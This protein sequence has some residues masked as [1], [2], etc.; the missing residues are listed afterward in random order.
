MTTRWLAAG[1]VALLLGACDPNNDNDNDNEAGQIVDDLPTVPP[2]PESHEEIVLPEQVIPPATEQQYCL[3]LPPSD[4]DRFMVTFDAYQGKHGHHLLMF[5][6]IQQREPGTVIECSDPAIMAQLLPAAF[7]RNFLPRDP[8]PNMAVRIKAGA[9]LVIQQHYVNTSSNP[10]RTVDVLHLETLQ[11]S[12]VETELG[13]FGLTDVNFSLPPGKQ[14]LQFDCEVTRP[15]IRLLMFGPHMH[16]WGSRFVVEAGA[17]DSMTIKH[18]VVNWMP[19]YRD[20]PPIADF[21]DDPLVLHA[22][23]KVRVTCEFDNDTDSELKFPTEM[24][25]TYGYFY[26]VTEGSQWICVP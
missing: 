2:L 3:F 7:S 1:P 15:E 22:Q 5:Q 14:T 19:S 24:C 13:F 12:Q 16:E 17:P 9:Q 21:F 10:I 23:D 26:P 11:E 18:E 4:V 25:A 6:A 8:P 20:L